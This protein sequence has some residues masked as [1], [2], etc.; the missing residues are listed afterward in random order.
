MPEEIGGEIRA[1]EARAGGVG[2]AEICVRRSHQRRHEEKHEEQHPRVR[3]G[4]A[5]SHAQ[6]AGTRGAEPIE[7]RGG[8]HQPRR[9]ER[10]CGGYAAGDDGPER[11]LGEAVA[12]QHADDP[13]CRVPAAED[14]KP[15]R[16]ARQGC[17]AVDRQVEET[18]GPGE[19]ADQREERAGEQQRGGDHCG[20][21]VRGMPP[22]A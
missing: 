3:A 18:A 13:A 5:R 21:A 16:Q 4:P 8:D 1:I 7:Q 6:A 11:Q 20:G 19:Q 2:A 14:G 15:D 17:T 9:Q 12:D 10:P 22:V